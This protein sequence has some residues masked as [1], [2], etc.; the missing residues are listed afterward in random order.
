MFKISW[1][2]ALLKK[3]IFY[4]L[5]SNFAIILSLFVCLYDFSSYYLL[6]TFI[7]RESKDSFQ[8]FNETLVKLSFLVDGAFFV[9]S[10]PFTTDLREVLFC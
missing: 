8:C 6:I 4:L 3:W 2:Q 9:S 10:W 1:Y 7:I 5:I